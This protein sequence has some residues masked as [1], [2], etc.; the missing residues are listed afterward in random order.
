MKKNKIYIL[1]T[2]LLLIP[3]KYY[4]DENYKTTK[5]IYNNYYFFDESEIVCTPPDCSG[6]PIEKELGGSKNS[7][8]F[9]KVVAGANQDGYGTIIPLSR[10]CENKNDACW[11]FEKFYYTQAANYKGKLI[12]YDLGEALKGI[13]DGIEK[14]TMC[15]TYYTTSGN[16]ETINNKY[17]SHGCYK[18]ANEEKWNTDD[19]G[20]SYSEI[21][22]LEL[23]CSAVP[24]SPVISM[25]RKNGYLSAEITR[26]EFDFDKENI[27]TKLINSNSN[28]NS[29]PD[30]IYP[31]NYNGNYI[32]NEPALYKYKY[33]VPENECITKVS[34]NEN[35]CNNTTTISNKCDKETV[36]SDDYYANISLNQTGYVTNLLSPDKIY[37]GGGVKFGF[38][39][40]N[41]V[42]WEILDTPI[43]DLSTIKNVI[44]KKFKNNEE[45][46]NDIS[47]S[48]DI[49]DKN[50]DLI[51]NF[52]N[53]DVL[54]ECSI[55]RSSVNDIR[56]TITTICEF[57]LPESKISDYTGE[58]QYISTGKPNINNMY[59][60]PIDYNYND[61]HF[62]ASL[63]NL[64]VIKEKWVGNWNL[65]YDFS[66]NSDDS[67][68]V[69]VYN[70]LNY[71]Y[72][73]ID[74]NKPFPNIGLTRHVGFNWVDWWNEH[75]DD[76]EYFSNK[77]EYTATLDNKKIAEI[78]EYNNNKHGYLSWEDIDKDGKSNFIKNNKNIFQEGDG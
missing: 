19:N 60:T 33:T 22:L 10:D 34:K 44:D 42:N 57:S 45:I 41:T 71:E 73:P 35:G 5:V 27:Q 32:I 1:L 13:E 49:K 11:G 56:G 51:Q 7:T 72:R 16:G 31:I 3:N 26:K 74:L 9:Y 55:T 47:V 12:E 78:K 48:I 69:D 67:C 75:K 25:V 6:S 40:Y 66:A 58:V 4:A 62:T 8:F 68:K 30:G 14:G 52:A 24:I 20:Y 17:Y 59:Y 53:G 54:K 39:Y 65:S 43:G 61:L 46:E 37:S 64:S 15:H 29:C 18:N 38:V 63:E 23:A 50:E 77:L 70:G 2:L 36:R 76:K 21:P 28:M